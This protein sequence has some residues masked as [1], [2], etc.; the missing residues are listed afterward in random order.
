MDQPHLCVDPVCGGVRGELVPEWPHHS[1]ALEDGGEPVV[2]HLRGVQVEESVEHWQQGVLGKQRLPGH[3]GH[4]APG[5]HTGVLAREE[6]GA[7]PHL[8][9]GVQ[10]VVIPTEGIEGPK[11]LLPCT[12]LLGGVLNKATDVGPH[13]GN[14]KLVKLQHPWRFILEEVQSATNDGVVHVVPARPVVP[15]PVSRPLARARE[16]RPGQE[17]R[18][19]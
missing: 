12:Q 18:V 19:C 10:V 17:G 5:P 9:Y 8:V 16:G 4:Q 6:T 7:G 3:P 1:G 11:L 2:P 14:T 13:Q 15:Q